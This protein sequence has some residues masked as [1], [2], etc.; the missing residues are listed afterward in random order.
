MNLRNLRIVYRKETPICNLYL[1]MMDGMGVNRETFGAS[2]G[3]LPEL[4]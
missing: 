3:H 1:T 2:T 4:T